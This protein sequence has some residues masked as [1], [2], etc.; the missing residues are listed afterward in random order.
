MTKKIAVILF[1]VFIV[2]IIGFIVSYSLVEDAK[3][4]HTIRVDKESKTAYQDINSIVIETDSTDIKIYTTENDEIQVKYKGKIHCFLCDSDVKYSFG[5]NDDILKIK[6]ETS[7]F[8]ATFYSSLRMDIYVPEE[9]SKNITVKGMSS[10][11][12]INN[13]NITSL[14]VKT[15]SGD[16]YLK[17]IEIEDN[18]DL[19][20]VSGEIEMN[21]IRANIIFETSAGDVEGENIEGNI[22]GETISGDVEIEII[23]DKFEVDI[24]T[25]TGEVEI[26]LLK[27]ASFSYT[28]DTV[29][30]DI[31]IEFEYDKEIHKPSYK[32]GIVKDGL[33]KIKV[34][35]VSGDVTIKR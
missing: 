26:Q 30:G 20:T 3:L 18:L 5:V 9:Y 4:Y 23:S 35:T 24:E 19:N 21:T 15:L 10:D 31:E 7:S 32:T 29:S 22:K 14:K 28:L 16:I 2:S 13:L 12:S 6:S 33:N 11:V 25:V 17:N 27:D 8:G 34:K 1:L